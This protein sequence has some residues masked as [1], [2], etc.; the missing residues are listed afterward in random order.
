MVHCGDFDA[1]MLKEAWETCARQDPS[2]SP[3]PSLLQK[4]CNIKDL[5]FNAAVQKN[6]DKND[7]AFN[8]LAQDMDGM[9]KLASF[10]RVPREDV[11]LEHHHLGMY[12]TDPWNAVRIRS[13]LVL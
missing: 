10:L 1:R 4:W 12:D 7:E 11:K 8:A 13:C 5:V 9:N 3:F 6:I 2:F